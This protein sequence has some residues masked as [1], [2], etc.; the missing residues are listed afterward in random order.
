MAAVI[1]CT[2]RLQPLHLGHLRFWMEVRRKYQQHLVICVLRR[3]GQVESLRLGLRNPDTF[4]EFSRFAFAIE[5]NPLPNWER[6]RLTS[7]AVA[8]EPLLAQN[9]TV[10]LRNRPDVSWDSSIE[11]L[12]KDRRWVFNVIS[13]PTF[14]RAKVEFYKSRGEKVLELELGRFG[15]F[16]GDQIRKLLRTGNNDLSFLPSACQEF[17]KEH[18]L[19]HF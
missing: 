10:L 7:L 19:K 6:L 3:S 16:D 1:I 18:C 5:R 4:E 17:F 2:H 15:G 11:D 13:E 14:S 9:T 8:S 12:P